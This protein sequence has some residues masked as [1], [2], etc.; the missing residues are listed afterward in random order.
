[1]KL[2]LKPSMREK[3]HYLLIQSSKPLKE[4]ELKA[5][6]NTAILKFIGVL[7]YANA[8]PLFVKIEEKN[9]ANILKKKNLIVLSVTT[10]FVDH[11]K[12]ALILE[13]MN[14]IRVSGTL[15]KLKEFLMNK[16]I[17]D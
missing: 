17:D 10:R 6:I 3:R 12:I 1:M 14:C 7:G 15:K 4:K 16:E 2:K 8:G 11:V 9:G 5:K 13:H